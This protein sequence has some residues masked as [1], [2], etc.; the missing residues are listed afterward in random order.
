LVWSRRIVAFKGASL[1]GEGAIELPFCANAKER[2]A[3]T[4]ISSAKKVLIIL[5]ELKK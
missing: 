4:E 1:I 2:L 5:N 3:E